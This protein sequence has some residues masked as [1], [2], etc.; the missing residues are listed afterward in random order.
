M[1]AI[2]CLE[3]WTRSVLWWHLLLP[4][5]SLVWTSNPKLHNSNFNDVKSFSVLQN[6]IVYLVVLMLMQ[7]SKRGISRISILALILL[8]VCVYTHYRVI[9]RIFSWMH[10][11]PFSALLH[12][13][14]LKNIFVRWCIDWA[15]IIPFEE[16][17]CNMWFWLHARY[18][19][20]D[21]SSVVAVAI[22]YVELRSSFV[23]I[24]TPNFCC[25]Y[26]APAAIRY[27]L[28]RSYFLFLVMHITRILSTLLVYYLT[29][30]R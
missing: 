14:K 1:Y 21:F 9:M 5:S 2:S 13:P 24:E 20:H 12:I 15:V 8:C 6:F 7:A 29:I 26:G 4:T 18:L 16:R 23:P 30:L 27:I 22:A 17:S 10:E 11:C 3:E 19:V 28:L 25:V